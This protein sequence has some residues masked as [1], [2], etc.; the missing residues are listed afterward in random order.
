MINIVI[1]LNK[2]NIEF[3]VHFILECSSQFEVYMFILFQRDK[4]RRLKCLG[5]PQSI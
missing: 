3:N 1:V 2:T 5:L 4:G